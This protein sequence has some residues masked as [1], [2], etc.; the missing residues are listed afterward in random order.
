MCNQ[1]RTVDLKA[2]QGKFIEMLPNDVIDE[3]L[4]KLQAIFEMV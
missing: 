4:A 3:V 1:P 2:R